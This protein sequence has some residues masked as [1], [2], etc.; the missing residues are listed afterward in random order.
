MRLQR[1]G[2][3]SPFFREV[4]NNNKEP[5]DL[6]EKHSLTFSATR[7]AIAQKSSKSQVLFNYLPQSIIQ[8]LKL[9]A[10]QILQSSAMCV[11]L[12]K[13]L[14]FP[15]HRTVSP[16]LNRKCSLLK[17]EKTE[18]YLCQAIRFPETIALITDCDSPYRCMIITVWIAIRS[19]SCRSFKPRE[20][21]SLSA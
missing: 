9:T 7:K 18:R 17:N 13:C 4:F 14:I 2:E 12:W 20:R 5:T 10:N 3:E 11:Y 16:L 15:L 19:Y 21:E 1:S 8:K 6:V